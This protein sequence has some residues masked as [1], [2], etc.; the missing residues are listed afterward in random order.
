MEISI[1]LQA[2][3]LKAGW[4]LVAI[5]LDLALGVTVALKQGIFEWKRLADVLSSYGP[6][7]VGWISLEVLDLL[8]PE[9][10]LLGGL[11]NALGT[12]AYVLLFGSA[13][14][15]VLGHIQT[16]GLLPNLSKAGL[17]PTDKS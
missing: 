11:G 2:I 8:P 14:G 7:I 10:K 13:I 5:L 9:Y 15:S 4:L 1:V 3:V 12:G 16:L 6:K 17:P